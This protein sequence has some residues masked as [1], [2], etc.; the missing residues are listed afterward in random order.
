MLPTDGSNIT[1]I[2]ALKIG[3]RQNVGAW[4][5]I[6]GSGIVVL[7]Y[8][9]GDHAKDVTWDP[10][11]ACKRILPRIIPP[12]FRTTQDMDKNFRDARINFNNVRQ[13][14]KMA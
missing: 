4:T 8:R 13:S 6:Q 9:T 1:R 3:I 7:R 12:I 5:D 10:Y 14:S 2:I 11:T